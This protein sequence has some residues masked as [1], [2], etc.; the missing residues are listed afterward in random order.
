MGITEAAISAGSAIVVAI[1]GFLSVRNTQL[2]LA[3][4]R[5]ELSF[6]HDAL[7]LRLEAHQWDTINQELVCLVR[8]TPID[9]FI[10]FCGWNGTDDPHWITAVYQYRSGD[11]THVA[12]VHQETDY[13][14]IQKLR[15]AKV[16]GEIVFKTG[17]IHDGLIKQIYM[18]EQVKS[19]AWFHLDSRMI[20][21]TK[22]KAV[23]FCSF[24]THKDVDIDNDTLVHCRR[25]VSMLRGAM[26]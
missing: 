18:A 23:R 22:S 16:A 2:R 9:R 25:I 1:I 8:D 4:T 3:Q 5:R 11:Q 13:E 17:D 19:A 24:A 10:I 26:K 21:G 12:Y 15:E 6:Q 7:S 14:Y 20:P